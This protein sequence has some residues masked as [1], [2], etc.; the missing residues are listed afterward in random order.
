MSVIDTFEII[1]GYY[2]DQRFVMRGLAGKAVNYV[3]KVEGLLSLARIINNS[4]EAVDFTIDHDTQINLTVSQF[5][6]FRIELL[7]IANELRSR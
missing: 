1:D 7:A 5:K 4:C 6:K 3:Y 2:D